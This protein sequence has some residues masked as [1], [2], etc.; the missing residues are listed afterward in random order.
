MQCRYTCMAFFHVFPCSPII[1]DTI[2]YSLA[3]HIFSIKIWQ[4]IFNC[5]RIAGNTFQISDAI[6]V[7][8]NKISGFLQVVDLIIACYQMIVD[9][10]LRTII[11]SNKPLPRLR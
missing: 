6:S 8:R 7:S 1:A 4:C 3:V 5:S 10:T 9:R 2:F 11:D